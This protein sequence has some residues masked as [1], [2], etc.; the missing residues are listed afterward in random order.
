MSENSSLLSGDDT[1]SERVRFDD[2][3]SFIDEN[4]SEVVSVPLSADQQQ[5]PSRLLKVSLFATLTSFWGVLFGAVWR[6]HYNLEL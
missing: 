5:I 6:V 1:T 2:N 3:V 4:L